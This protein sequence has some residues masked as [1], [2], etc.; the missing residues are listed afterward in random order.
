MQLLNDRYEIV[1]TPRWLTTKLNHM[2]EVMMRI[3]DFGLLR[4]RQ[5]LRLPTT[6]RHRKFLD[7][8]RESLL[9]NKVTQVPLSWATPYRLQKDILF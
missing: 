8:S 4:T 5:L 6:K 7:E 2:I 3:V 1:H 9:S